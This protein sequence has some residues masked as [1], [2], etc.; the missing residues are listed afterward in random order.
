MGMEPALGQARGQP[1]RYTARVST[2]G[3]EG[4]RQAAWPDRQFPRRSLRRRHP[5][6]PLQALGAELSQAW[7]NFARSG[8][9][10]QRGLAWPAYD[11]A[12][13]QMMI[14]DTVSH[15]VAD[16]DREARVLLGA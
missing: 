1:L 6:A 5:P 8:N 11:V 12:Q 16:P 7:I 14:F 9:P 15:V 4:P 13:R 3:R 10:S 2:T